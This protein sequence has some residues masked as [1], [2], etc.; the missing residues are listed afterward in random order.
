M[1]ITWPKLVAHFP[2]KKPD[3]D[4]AHEL[5]ESLLGLQSPSA[6]KRRHD[7]EEFE[8]RGGSTKSTESKKTLVIGF[9]KSILFGSY[10]INSPKID[11]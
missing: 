11:K 3:A 5:I 7:H 6:K 2:E 10:G 4:V 1:E 8:L 9:V